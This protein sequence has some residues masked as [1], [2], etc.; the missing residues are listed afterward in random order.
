MK[1]LLLLVEKEAGVSKT[2]SV[3]RYESFLSSKVGS[4]IKCSPASDRITRDISFC[5]RGLLG[6]KFP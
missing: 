3:V 1:E 2:V 6:I 5:V 4:R